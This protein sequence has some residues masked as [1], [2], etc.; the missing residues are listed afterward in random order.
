[1]CTSGLF[2][3]HFA[4]AH[5]RFHM[6][7]HAN[8]MIS[9]VTSHEHEQTCTLPPDH[10]RCNLI[11][12]CAGKSDISGYVRDMFTHHVGCYGVDKIADTGQ[13][14]VTT[15]QSFGGWFIWKM[16]G[17]C[18]RGRRILIVCFPSLTSR[19]LSF[20]PHIVKRA[21]LSRSCLRILPRMHQ[22]SRGR[23]WCLLF[24]QSVNDPICACVLPGLQ[25]S[26]WQIQWCHIRDYKP[27]MQ[28]FGSFE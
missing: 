3:I 13:R 8:R 7:S 10:S 9:S 12:N 24:L 23:L 6:R 22:S 17:N 19:L 25:C 26:S 21:W 4:Y 11:L 14:F 20:K 18:N 16:A 15:F 1:M 28:A 2:D 5:V 27:S